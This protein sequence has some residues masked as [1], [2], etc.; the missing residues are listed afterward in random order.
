MKISNDRQ[1]IVDW[2]I[3]YVKDYKEQKGA[4][5][6]WGEPLVAFANAADP[7]FAKLKDIVSPS[8][9]LPSDLVPNAKSVIAFFIPFSQKIVYSNLKG[10]ESSKDWDIANIESHQLVGDINV[11]LR[12][13][14]GKIGYAASLIPASYDYD[15]ETL[16]SNWSH[17]H[18]AYIA[19]LGTF[20]IHNLLIT[21]KGC[22]GVIGT[23]ITDMPLEPTKQYSEENCLYLRDGICTRCVSRCVARAMST[24]NGY[25]YVDRGK[26]NAQI[27]D[28]KVP[29]YEN[30][31]GDACGKCMCGV[32][33]STRN[34]VG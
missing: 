27:Y 28:T 15:E 33:C 6:E 12:E 14:L 5:S 13:D 24:K 22:C 32:P 7:Q 25:P 17:R 16:G 19:G 3:N 1:S 23:I 11:A 2:V 20:G 18:A 21:E 9:A 10:K 4:E 31:I 30:G 29:V 8:H 34:P 26:C